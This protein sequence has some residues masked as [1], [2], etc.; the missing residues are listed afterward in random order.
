MVGVTERGPVN[1][2]ILVTSY[3]EYTRIF[4]GLLNPTDYLSPYNYLVALSSGDLRKVLHFIIG[5]AS[6]PL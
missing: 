6:K 5:H 1:V 2:P 4:G 3:G